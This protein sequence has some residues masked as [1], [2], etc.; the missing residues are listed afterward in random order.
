M[1]DLDGC[2]N[3]IGR[4]L[5]PGGCLCAAFIHPFLSAFDT[6]AYKQEQLTLKEP[7]LTERPYIDHTERAD[8]AMTFIS[9]HRPLS[10]YL[11]A[12]FA[13]GFVMDRFSE[14][15]TKPIPWL[16]TTR[17]LRTMSTSG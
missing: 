6:D 8:L 10:R 17:L 13:A 4:V 12:F 2:V 1:D 9:M 7:Y 16:V 3:E 15:G 11:G 14:F 5:R